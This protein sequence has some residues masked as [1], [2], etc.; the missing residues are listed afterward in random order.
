MA[1]Q[2]FQARIRT[3]GGGPR[4]VIDRRTSRPIDISPITLAGAIQFRV[5]G[6]ASTTVEL[7]FL[8]AFFQIDR[9]AV[10]YPAASGTYSLVMPAY[11]D[12]TSQVLVAAAASG[13]STADATLVP[14]KFASYSIARP[15]QLIGASLTGTFGVAIWGLPLDDASEH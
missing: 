6:V 14:A 5:S 15:I 12:L 4:S 10:T 7:G 13:T 9:V 2:L 1:K 3:T 11:G 8:P